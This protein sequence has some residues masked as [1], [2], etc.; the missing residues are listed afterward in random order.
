MLIVIICIIFLVFLLYSFIPSNINKKRFFNRKALNND[1]KNIYLT[2]DDG[3]SEYTEELL[4]LLNKYNVKATFFCVANFAQKYPEIIS[5][6]KEEGHYIALHS[7]KHKNSMLQGMLE[8]KKDLKQSL[9]IMQNLKV[10]IRYYRPPWGDANIFLQY[11]LKKE[12]I[13]MILWDVM[14]E[15][16]Q[17]DT[18]DEIIKQKLLSR[19]KAGNIICLHDGRGSNEAP[20]RTI[21]ALEKVIP[22]L[23]DE[24]Y[25]FKTIEGYEKQ[26]EFKN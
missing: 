18:T 14:A 11:L 26:Y 17:G 2:F 3:P 5:R 21:K 13:E 19:V 9:E 25:K 4:N 12:R 7:L 22:I 8:T 6:F 24:G 23:L 20:K 15:D 16:W 1:E 10:E